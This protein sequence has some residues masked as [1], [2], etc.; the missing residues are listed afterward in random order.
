MWEIY[1]AG[2]YEILMRLWKE[3]GPGLELVVSENGVCVPDDP[4][5]DGRVRD[6]RRS[7]YLHRHLAQ[8]H[9]ALADGVPVSGYFVWSLLDNFEWAHGY[10]KRFGLA[11]VDYATL[12]RT[13][14]DSGRW[15]AG[16]IQANGVQGLE[17][18][19]A[20]G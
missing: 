17:T 19:P 6:E 4:D 20:A 16:V 18:A 15:Y 9:R 12:A 11:Y 10:S 7:R 2:L 8:V 5:F 3:H 1:P 14:K 13:L